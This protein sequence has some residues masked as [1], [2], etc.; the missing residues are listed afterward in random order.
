MDRLVVDWGN[1]RNRSVI[2]H[3]K[4]KH[5]RN[6]TVWRPPRRRL[7]YLPDCDPLQVWIGSLQ[8]GAR[9]LY[10][11]GRLIHPG[12]F[13]FLFLFLF[14]FRSFPAH[15]S[16]RYIVLFAWLCSS[17]VSR[18]RVVW[19]TTR[20]NSQYP[21][22]FLPSI[23]TLTFFF[24]FAVNDSVAAAQQPGPSCPRVLPQLTISQRPGPS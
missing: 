24:P 14:Y 19:G 8:F 10:C 11:H 16:C 1:F 15:V 4:S 22:F 12:I 21:V 5:F 20:I 23:F 9:S 13:L 3:I 18:G 2:Y 7:P 17:Q 6:R